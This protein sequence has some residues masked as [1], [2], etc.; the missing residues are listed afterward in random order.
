MVDWLFISHFDMCY[1]SGR[2]VGAST[3]ENNYDFQVTVTALL[4]KKKDTCS[5]RAEFD[6]DQME[7]FHIRKHVC[8]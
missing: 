2:K 8:S 6:L 7:G 3:I 5:V 1:N 4:K